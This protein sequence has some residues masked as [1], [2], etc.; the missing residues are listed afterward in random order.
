MAAPM[1]AIAQL[2]DADEDTSG[3]WCTRSARR[4]WRRWALG[5]WEAIPT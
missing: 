3:M 1:T 4:G 2:V 5:R